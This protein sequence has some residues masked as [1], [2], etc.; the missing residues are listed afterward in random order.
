VADTTALSDVLVTP[1][2][3]VAVSEVAAPHGQVIDTWD[4]SGTRVSVTSA[5]GSTVTVRQ[6]TA[7]QPPPI[8]NG[9]VY[10]CLPQIN[11]PGVGLAGGVQ[12]VDDSKVT[13]AIRTLEATVKP[14]LMAKLDGNPTIGQ[15]MNVSMAEEGRIVQSWCV[16]LAPENGKGHA[17]ACDV[18][19]MDQD[20]G[21]GDWY[22]ADEQEVTG[23]MNDMQRLYVYVEYE[24]SGDTF[25]HWSPNGWVST[26]SCTTQ[27]VGV[28]GFGASYSESWEACPDQYGPWMYTTNRGF[29]QFGAQW[30]GGTDDSRGVDAVD[31]VHS[32]S[33]AC[34]C[35]V[36]W[37]G[38]TWGG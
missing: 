14:P 37:V 23:Q 7:P 6:V 2:A 35:P 15:V 29:N 36:L 33:S 26:G 21:D 13:P 24:N 30:M 19:R 18:Q 20:N 28:S 16:D 8:C 3:H 32:P 4:V 17:H 5:P 34:N 27:T 12:P 11:E 9:S 1:L 38:M 25:V 10:Y 22:L 31:L